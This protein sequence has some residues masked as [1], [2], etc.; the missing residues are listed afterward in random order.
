MQVA[1]PLSRW[2]RCKCELKIN[3]FFIKV[4][5]MNY[6]MH[7]LDSNLYMGLSTKMNFKAQISDLNFL[8]IS[9]SSC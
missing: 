4:L 7:Q 9:Q 3:C 5:N 1:G 2:A 8:L 6:W